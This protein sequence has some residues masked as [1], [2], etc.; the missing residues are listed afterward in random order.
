VRFANFRR[1][2]LADLVDEAL[3]GHADIHG[4]EKP[5]KR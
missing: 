4:F 1:K 5:P 2:D 3:E